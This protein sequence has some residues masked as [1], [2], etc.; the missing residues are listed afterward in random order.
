VFVRC[1]DLAVL[2]RII[3]RVRRCFDLD[4]DPSVI[5]T[6]LAAD[7]LVAGPVSAS[8][9][10]RLVAS[11]EGF[12]GVVRAILGQQVT[13]AAGVG[14]GNQLVSVLGVPLPHPFGGG[15]QF[16]LLF[17]EPKVVAEADLSFLKMPRQRQRTLQAAAQ[18]F[19]DNPAILEG[20][21]LEVRA[22]LQAI[23]GIG[24]WTL[25]YIALRVLRDPDALPV[26]DVALQRAFGA[27]SDVD[28]ATHGEVWR[29]W[30]SYAT[31]HLW[32]TL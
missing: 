17:P 20:E 24:P 14:L 32:E 8:P 29:P 23:S 9:G 27:L 28:L 13:V 11:W 21:A 3:A 31:Q 19:V 26:G 10:L 4:C 30:R 25:D 12:E 16:S 15:A 7:A 5:A 2:P 1:A 6:H 22:R 18:A